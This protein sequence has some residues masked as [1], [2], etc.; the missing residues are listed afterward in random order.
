MVDPESINFLLK[1]VDPESK[2]FDQILGPLPL[3]TSL[4]GDE[5]IRPY[6]SEGTKNFRVGIDP[7]KFEKFHEI[8]QISLQQNDKKF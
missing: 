8:I 6:K 5:R 3:A 1:V 2:I 4:K 7:T